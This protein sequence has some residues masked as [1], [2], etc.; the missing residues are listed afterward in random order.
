VT[1][2]PVVTAA[3]QGALAAEHAAIFGYGTL[4]PHLP[5]VRISQARAFER[6]HRTIRDAVLAAM[7]AQ[8]VPPVAPRADY[9]PPFP[10]TT[11][12]RSDSYA[13]RLEE[14]CA[15]AWRYLVAV[16]AEHTQPQ[17]EL[18]AFAVTALASSAVRAMRWRSV[19]TPTQPTVAF[20]GIDS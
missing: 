7:T 16:A 10:L 12:P 17:P 5:S 14:A 8:A 15:A 18:R 11:G 19:L 9:P 2:L 20:P 4:G 13:Q 6:A 1:P 3:W